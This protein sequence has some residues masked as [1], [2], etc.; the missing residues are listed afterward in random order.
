MKQKDKY[1]LDNWNYDKTYTDTRKC[2]NKN[3]YDGNS[4]NTF[5][6]QV[7]EN[8]NQYHSCFFD[9]KVNITKLNNIKYKQN[10]FEYLLNTNA[11]CKLFFDIDK[12]KINITDLKP[13]LNELFDFIDE[14]CDKKLNRKKYL[15][16]YKKLVDKDFNEL[17]IYTR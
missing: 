14:L 2:Y 13:L 8:Y 3:I 17:H 1:K 11:E 12:I 5:L 10:L 16:F 6:K 4:K 15:V 7:K 9:G